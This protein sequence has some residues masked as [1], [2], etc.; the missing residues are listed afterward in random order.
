MIRAVEDV[1]RE[2]K[3]RKGERC[4]WETMWQEVGDYIIPRKN[5]INM[6]VSPGAKRNLNILD[7]T[8]MTS[9]EDL[10]GAIYGMMT[11]TTGE[12]FGLTT[13]DPGLDMRDDVRK[14]FE[15]TASRMHSILN[16]SNFYTEIQEYYLD[17]CGFNTAGMTILEDQDTIVTF[18]AHFL[19]ELYIRENNKGIV[20]DVYRCY[21]WDVRQIIQEYGEKNVPESVLECW[22]NN[23]TET[24]FEIIHAVYPADIS[25]K[26]KKGFTQKFVSQH[27]LVKDKFELR[28]KGFNENIWV[29]ARWAKA[30]GEVYGRGPGINA[31]PEVKMVNL[32]DETVIKSAQLRLGPPLQAPDDGYSLPIKIKPYSISYYRAGS[33]KDDRIQPLFDPPDIQFAEPIMESRRQRIRQAFY[34]DKLNTPKIDRQTTVE[35]TQRAQEQYRFLGPLVGRLEKEFLSSTIDRVFQIGLRRNK[36][37]PPPDALQGKEYGVKYSSQI[38]KIQKMGEAQSIFQYLQGLAQLM[39]I[40]PSVVQNVDADAVARG[41]APIFGFP[42]RFIR[43]EDKVTE[44]RQ[45]AAQAASEKAKQ[46]QDLNESQVVKNTASAIPAASAALGG[47]EEEVA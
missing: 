8:G 25:G 3:R 27:I 46:E 34:V 15:D 19:K 35:V 11:P 36:F 29:V 24:K 44:M 6:F 1:I 26:K 23:K 31:L 13:G 37:L 18:K 16:N 42:Q 5:D 43:D 40:D 45:A 30:S 17:L 28:V 20:D 9:C 33:N 32:M 39:G 22:K 21:E 38:A 12:W 10:S 47:E 7:N 2:Y 41:I 4:N 14:W